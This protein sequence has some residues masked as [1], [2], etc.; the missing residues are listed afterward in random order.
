VTDESPNDTDV[1]DGLPATT[2]LIVNVLDTSDAA[3]YEPSPADEAVT[4]Q[5]PIVLMLTT[6]VDASTAQTD[7]VDVAYVT[8]LPDDTVAPAA[9]AGSSKS[10]PEIAGN[11]IV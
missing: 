11:V 7:P 3:A 8:V 6:P 2:G 9:K 10:F 1:T 4:V 5:S